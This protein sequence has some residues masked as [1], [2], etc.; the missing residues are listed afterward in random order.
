ML[1]NLTMELFHG[2]SQ[3][4]AAGAL[5]RPEIAAAHGRSGS[6]CACPYSASVD[7]DR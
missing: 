1:C 7:L 3:R 6:S 4:D 2:P 5:C